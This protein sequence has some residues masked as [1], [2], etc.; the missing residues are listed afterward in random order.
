MISK[1]QLMISNH[2]KI[3]LNFDEKNT[4]I[5]NLLLDYYKYSHQIKFN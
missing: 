5:S 3:I 4:L 1:N 2:K